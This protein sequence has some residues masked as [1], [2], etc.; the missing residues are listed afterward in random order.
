[1]KKIPFILIFICA[2]ANGQSIKELYT[3]RFENDWKVYEDENYVKKYIDTTI[4]Y[5]LESGR[6]PEQELL[7]QAKENLNKRAER[8]SK[9]LNSL[10]INI[11][12]LDSLSFIE[13]RSRNINFEGNY[14]N[15]GAVFAKDS[16]YGFTYDYSKENFKIE[17]Y[18]YFQN[19]ENE[20]INQ[21]K[22]IIGN[23]IISA[24]TNYLDT[25]AKVEKEM[26]AGPLKELN[27]ETEFEILIYNKKR[28]NELRRIYL[29]ETFVRI[30]NQK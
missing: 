7:F 13:Q 20:T 8:I 22:Q 24:K 12:E 25:I 9:I 27:P 23:L 21:A 1:M 10:K 26:F 15:K 19:S 29:H 17:S 4:V 3:G 28:E 11:A 2:F 16:I 30:M 5:K 6:S 18:G 14:V